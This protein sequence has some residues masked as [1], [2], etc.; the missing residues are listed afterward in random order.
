MC[1]FQH[2]PKFYRRVNLE[3]HNASNFHTQNGIFQAAPAAVPDKH[4]SQRCPSSAAAVNP[5][6]NNDTHSNSRTEPSSKCELRPSPLCWASPDA[7]PTDIHTSDD[8]NG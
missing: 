4:I 2:A 6:G 5:G 7:T 8:T 1:H 3:P